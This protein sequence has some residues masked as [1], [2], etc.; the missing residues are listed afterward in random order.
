MASGLFVVF[1]GID[2]SGKSTL[3]KAVWDRLGTQAQL[4][5]EPTGLH[6]GKLIREKLSA[7]QTIPQKDWIQLFTEDRALD[8]E[9]HLKPALA[10]GKIVLMDRY[11]YS[12]AAY[13]GANLPDL[14][15]AEIVKAQQA[16]FPEPDMLVYL[17]ISPEAA[18]ARIS[19]RPGLEIFETRSQL[20]RISKNYESIL[21]KGT[22]RLNAT[23]S[24][25]SNVQTVQR[26][27]ET[28]VPI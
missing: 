12:T 9:Q 8:V 3:T 22:L 20:E 13:Q 17:E 26:A 10:A 19:S 11:Y 27:I 14:S 24:V 4:L 7:P 28:K 2:G 6:T 25:D 15:A 16:M 18:L 23:K 21:P 5:R 1:E